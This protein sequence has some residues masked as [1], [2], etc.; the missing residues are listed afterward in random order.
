[1]L[2]DYLLRIDG[3]SKIDDTIESR[4][5]LHLSLGKGLVW[6]NEYY[7]ITNIECFVIANSSKTV[8]IVDVRHVMFDSLSKTIQTKMLWEEHRNGRYNL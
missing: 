4:E 7:K 2:Y 3:S 6:N 8:Y 1:M 5:E